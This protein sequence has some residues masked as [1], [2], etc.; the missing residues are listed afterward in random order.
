MAGSCL[1]ADQVLK[2]LKTQI[3]ADL[4]V[5]DRTTSLSSDYISQAA[6]AVSQVLQN[7]GE[8]SAVAMNDALIS[9]RHNKLIPVLEN[10]Y[11]FNLGYQAERLELSKLAMGCF[12]LFINSMMRSTQAACDADTPGQRNQTRMDE[13]YTM[14]ED[15]GIAVAE[16]LTPGAAE[17]SIPGTIVSLSG[18]ATTRRCRGKGQNQR[19]SD[20]Y[21][22]LVG[23][24]PT[25]ELLSYIADV[26][27]EPVCEENPDIICGNQLSCTDILHQVAYV[28]HT[29][30]YT[31]DDRDFINPLPAEAQEDPH[32]Y[33]EIA[34]LFLEHLNLTQY[35]AVLKESLDEGINAPAELYAH[36][37]QVTAVAIVDL[38]QY[39]LPIAY[40][41]G[42]HK[43]G[44][45]YWN[46]ANEW[47]RQEVLNVDGPTLRATFANIQPAIAISAY[48]EDH[49]SPP[50]PIPLTPPSP[51]PPHPLTP[52]EIL[53]PPPPPPIVEQ[54]ELT[55]GIVVA[56]VVAGVSLCAYII[57]VFYR[58]RR[59][60]QEVHL[61]PIDEEPDI[62]PA[63]GVTATDIALNSEE[64]GFPNR[65]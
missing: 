28:Y 3:I 7:P 1:S 14:V 8:T 43:P 64:P 17:V 29:G 13:L 54:R 11:L 4:S 47:T 40:D 22:I 33:G 39:A 52:V 63:P 2:T 35:G 18:K 56:P 59:R 15:L 19:R 46:E 34:G 25:E 5:L 27:Q 42:T 58:R 32:L 48:V 21:G 30:A 9:L 62:S 57:F 12:S 60:I 36:G 10:Y 55:V 20:A 31:T 41:D 16:T 49:I 53:F 26:T 51:L 44:V 61:D 24:D 37:Q 6:C 65:L 38:Q 23:E 50:P 45:R